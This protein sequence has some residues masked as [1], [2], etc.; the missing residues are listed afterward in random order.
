MRRAFLLAF[1]LVLFCSI[2]HADELE[3]RWVLCQ[4]YVNIRARASANSDSIGR[5]MCG[6]ELT[7]DQTLRRGGRWWYHCV[8]MATEA[9]SGWVCADYCTDSRV[10]VC[11]EVCTIDA[12]GRVAMRTVVNGKRI[13]W[14]HPGDEVNVLAYSDEWALTT[15]GYIKTEYLE[16]DGGDE[17]E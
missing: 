16:F 15:R 2:A 9:G 5:L 7:I 13:R 8:D 4:S 1:I 3:Y 11:D 17:D 14:V 6:D 12:S 10:T